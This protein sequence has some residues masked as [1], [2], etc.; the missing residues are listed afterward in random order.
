MKRKWAVFICVLILLT[1]NA[2]YFIYL[3]RIHLYNF[4]I[5]I[6]RVWQLGLWVVRLKGLVTSFMM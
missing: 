2:D 1:I 3:S 4:V 6:N 5:L